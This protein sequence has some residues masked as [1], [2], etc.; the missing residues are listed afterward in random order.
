MPSVRRLALSFLPLLFVASVVPAFAQ[1]PVINGA[2]VTKGTLFVLGTNFG[3]KPTVIL[4]GTALSGVSVNSEG[5]EI[6]APVP[7][8]DAG[9]YTLVVSVGKR[10]V[11]SVVTIGAA[12]TPG[13]PGPPGAPGPAGAPGP[14]A[15]LVVDANEVVLGT[16]AVQG[17]DENLIV[18]SDGVAAMIRLRHQGFADDTSRIDFWHTE[19]S[20]SGARYMAVEGSITTRRLFQVA[21]GIEGRFAW[22]TDLGSRIV[23]LSSTKCPDGSDIAT[24]VGCWCDTGVMPEYIEKASPASAVLDLSA[25]VPPF[26]IR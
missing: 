4:A 10:Q 24:G 20:C 15:L 18:A 22:P 19:P 3:T 17:V 8:L 1:Q 2:R 7:A 11:S 21:V 5:T 14:G 13:P 6:T 9:S 12:G 16:Y 23:P 25:A 26:K